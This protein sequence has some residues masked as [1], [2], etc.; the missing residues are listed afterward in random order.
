VEGPVVGREAEVAKRIGVSLDI[1]RER[2]QVLKRRADIG[3]TGIFLQRELAPDESFEAVFEQ[4]VK[5]TPAMK[6]RVRK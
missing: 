1:V 4:L 5:S 3:H 6:F 2:V